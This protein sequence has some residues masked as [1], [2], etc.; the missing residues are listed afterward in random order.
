[1]MR[2]RMN[3]AGKRMRPNGNIRRLTCNLRNH[4]RTNRRFVRRMRYY[5]RNDAYYS[6]IGM[7][8]RRKFR[9]SG[10]NLRNY[11][12][13]M[14]RPVRRK[15]YRL[16]IAA[17][18]SGIGT[19]RRRKFR[20]SGCNLRNRRRTNRR[21]GRRM[22]YYRRNDAYYSGIGTRRRCK[23]RCSACNLR[24][25]RRMMRRFLGCKTRPAGT[26]QYPMRKI[27]CRL[28]D[29]SAEMHR[30]KKP[31]MRQRARLRIAQIAGIRTF[32]RFGRKI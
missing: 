31:T 18:Y 11:R 4:R 3:A 24:N 20:C 29:Y 1:M 32:G 17:Y 5:R 9:C 19:R 25:R 10:C 13:M 28:A 2:I 27:L 30:R 15:Y 23:F 14:R 8:R 21:L 12:R 7:R 6:G 16:G 26:E 22:H